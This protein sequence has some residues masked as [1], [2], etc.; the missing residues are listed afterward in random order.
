[1]QKE[2]VPTKPEKKSI[3]KRLKQSEEVKREARQQQNERGKDY[4]PNPKKKSY[5]QD[6]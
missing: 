3:R 6:L 2:A 4:E 1:V 5:E